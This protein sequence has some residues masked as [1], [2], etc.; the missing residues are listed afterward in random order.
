[1]KKVVS[2]MLPVLI[3][4]FGYDVFVN[5]TYTD[6]MAFRLGSSN[7]SVEKIEQDLKWLG[8]FEGTPD[9]YYGS[10]TKTAVVRFQ[11]D[12]GL[13]ADGVMDRKTLEALGRITAPRKKNNIQSS[14]MTLLTRAINGESRGEPY[15]GQVAVGA[16]IMNRT[17]DPRF[18]NTIAGVVYQPG[19]FTAINDG[20]I[21]SKLEATPKKAAQ[22]AMNGWDPTGGC[23][24]Y[25]NPAKTTNKWIW[26]RPVLKVIGK[27]RFAK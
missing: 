14:E 22:D 19:A 26:S 21:H 20:Q 18:P 3:L 15:I 27:H 25:Y 4:L 17:R 10:D 13:K 16:V 8:Y 24:Y 12:R 23:V 7:V 11:S 6:A 9:S 5:S 2:I 1:M